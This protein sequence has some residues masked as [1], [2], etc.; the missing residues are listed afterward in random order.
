MRAFNN[1]LFGDNG[2][3]HETWNFSEK[4]GQNR[5]LSEIRNAHRK[6]EGF[7]QLTSR[8]R[9]VPLRQNPS[10]Y[11]QLPLESGVRDHAVHAFFRRVDNCGRPVCAIEPVAVPM[12]DS[13]FVRLAVFVP[14]GRE[15]DCA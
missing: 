8:S 3:I 2:V 1:G 13:I 6:K 9:A 14:D 15:R 5:T 10:V 11:L 12:D 7:M 4:I